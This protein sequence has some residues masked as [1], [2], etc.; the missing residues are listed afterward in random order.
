MTNLPIDQP[1]Y[2]HNPEAWWEVRYFLR[3]GYMSVYTQAPNEFFAKLFASHSLELDGIPRHIITGIGCKQI[4][5]EDLPE[6]MKDAIS[7]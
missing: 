1:N 2:Y 4:D 6:D 5:Y 7:E 3:Y